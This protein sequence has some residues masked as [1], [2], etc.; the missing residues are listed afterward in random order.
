M[1]Y[2]DISVPFTLIKPGF[3]VTCGIRGCSTENVEIDGHE[4]L[5]VDN[6]VTDT[7]LFYDNQEEE[8]ALDQE[9]MKQRS[10]I[11]FTLKCKEVHT[12]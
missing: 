4:D 9:S 6:T 7:G 2:C 11:M 10:A 8:P 12:Q 5:L 3:Y 1:Q